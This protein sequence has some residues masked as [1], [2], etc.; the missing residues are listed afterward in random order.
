[1]RKEN[2]NDAIV[3]DCGEEQF[4]T[5]GDFPIR[6]FWRTKPPKVPFL[7]VFFNNFYPLIPNATAEE[8]P[9]K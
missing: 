3:P 9:P 2:K 7:F 4:E 1:M 6:K 5:F 8:G